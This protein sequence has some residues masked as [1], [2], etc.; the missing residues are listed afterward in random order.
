MVSTCK[1]RGRWFVVS[2][3]A[4]Q[5]QRER[6]KPIVLLCVFFENVHLMFV[7]KSKLLIVIEMTRFRH[8]NTFD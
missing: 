3:V 7:L 5:K 8:K 1:Y 6:G 4:S 2:F